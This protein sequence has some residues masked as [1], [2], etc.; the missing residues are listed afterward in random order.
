MID[1]NIYGPISAFYVPDK[2]YRRKYLAFTPEKLF[3]VISEEEAVAADYSEVKVSE[4]ECRVGAYTFEMHSPKLLCEL[5]EWEVAKKIRAL[6]TSLGTVTEDN[7]PRVE[8]KPEFVELLKILKSE[9]DI[10][11]FS[12]DYSKKPDIE[13]H[14]IENDRR[15]STR[16]TDKILGILSLIGTK[17]AVDDII[18][19]PEKREEERK[20][21][22]K[23]KSSLQIPGIPKHWRSG[24]SILI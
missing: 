5:A 7:L 4:N 24:C 20:R 11:G 21:R 17:S 12:K 15:F 13:T 3:G 8:T 10:C 23:R 9:F 22:K 14:Y 16:E 19:H 18:E 6:L 1:Q 2:E